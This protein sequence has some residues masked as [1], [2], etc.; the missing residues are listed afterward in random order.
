[1]KTPKSLL[2]DGI[3]A[4][5]RRA[6][7]A[8]IV[9]LTVLALGVFFVQ[10]G[11]PELKSVHE[12]RVVVVAENMVESGDWI[13]PIFNDQVR[14]EKP[15]LPYWIVGLSRVLGGS[16]QEPVFRFPSALLGIG[17]IGM[18]AA[19]AGLLFG[20]NSAL[21]TGLFTSLMFS[22]IIE[23]R[24]AEVD[25]YLTFCV[26]LCLLILCTILFGAVK[27]DWLWLMLGCAVALGGLAKG[28]VIFI[29]ALPLIGLGWWLYPDRRPG[30]LW[31]IGS[32]VVFT[33]ISS[34]WPLM[35][36][37][38]L[39]A[40]T[41]QEAWFSDI[42]RNVSDYHRSRRPPYFYLTRFFLMTF[43][44]SVLAGAAVLLPLWKEVRQDRLLWRK[45]LLL[46]LS[47]ALVVLCFS[48]VRKKKIDYLVPLAPIIG[49]LI[50]AA[51]DIMRQNI[52][53]NRPA[54]RSNKILLWAQALVIAATGTA[55]F[56]YA[57]FDP[58][59]RVTALVACGAAVCIGGVVGLLGILRHRLVSALLAQCA[60]IIILGYLL[61]GVLLPQENIRIS[62]GR[63]CAAVREVIEDA[64]VVFFRGRN[65]TL[66]YHL[67]RTIHRADTVD[68]LQQ[69]LEDHPDGFVLVQHT[70]LQEAQLAAEHIV[71]H[72]PRM[73]DNELPL[74]AL[75]TTRLDDDDEEEN[76]KQK[77][78]DEVGNFYN[79]YVLTAGDWHG[80][81]RE[82]A[83]IEVSAP[84]WL[85][86]E[87]LWV[88]FGLL[89]QML[90]FLR[91]LVQWIASEKAQ[92]SVIPVVFWWFSLG[93]GLMLLT[94]SIYR[95]DPV[96]I[97]GQ[98]TGVFIYIRNL[99]FIY[100]RPNRAQESQADLS[101]EFIDKE[102]A[103]QV[104]LLSPGK[105][106]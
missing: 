6:E 105:E 1:M 16:M 21:L 19:C 14:L 100:A 2:L 68:E 26:T 23:S 104:A 99:W 34:V 4:E 29:F 25:I 61:F 3:F 22:Y 88:G 106:K 5:S 66:V 8:A 96:F 55:A 91:F 102:Q 33:V 94:Y 43:P 81:S 57:V 71:F 63:F 75:R 87:V 90:F 10:L 38:H 30:V 48:F 92:K 80:T 56:V 78:D 82:F 31:L 74:P 37:G 64:P 59:G 11:F 42:M 103:D 72:H 51:W 20:R 101:S 36:I 47:I 52:M 41:V 97:F 7:A 13:V 53:E 70:N 86:A 50:A 32:M 73:R 17:G 24:S 49:I 67:G 28:P 9:L 69:F 98:S 60:G 27:R 44:W 77:E 54:A 40:R 84:G 35:L 45:T 83:A 58:F 89:A 95:M 18:A 93:G 39:G 79:I 85:T 12:A 15:P 46:T 76:E 62:P 65:E